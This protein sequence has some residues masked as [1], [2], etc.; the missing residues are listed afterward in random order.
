MI[1][2]VFV[3]DAGPFLVRDP[4][5]EQKYGFSLARSIDKAGDEGPMLSGYKCHIT[6]G[7]KPEPHHMA[8]MWNGGEIASLCEEHKIRIIVILCRNIG[9]NFQ[10]VLK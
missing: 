7:V 2:G 3:L 4:T 9:F 6:Q 10:E 8:G 5:T 1:Y